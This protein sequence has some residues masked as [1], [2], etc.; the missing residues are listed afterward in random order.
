MTQEVV[1]RQTRRESHSSIS[2]PSHSIAKSPH[3]TS[4]SHHSNKQ[5]T[6]YNNN[7]NITAMEANK[8]LSLIREEQEQK[9][10][11]EGH[12]TRPTLT[13]DF[14]FIDEAYALRFLKARKGNIQKA[15]EMLS[16]HIKWRN[17]FKTNELRFG[18]FGLTWLFGCWC[19]C[20]LLCGIIYHNKPPLSQMLR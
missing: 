15:K 3:S 16:D 8:L 9:Q 7:S 14:P 12:T 11:Q 4:S 2:S 17:E 1:K 20:N 5:N 13:I 10:K 19:V 6:N 18:R